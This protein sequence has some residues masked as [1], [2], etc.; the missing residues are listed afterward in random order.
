MPF[1][2]LLTVGIIGAGTSLA[3]GIL[4]SNAATKAA[5]TQS[6]ASL[7]AARLANETARMQADA[8]L[9]AS[10]EANTLGE[11]AYEQG[12]KDL[13]PW[14]EVGGE[15]IY[16]LR[17]LMQPEGYLAKASPTFDETMQFNKSDVMMD[18]GF[19]F[20]MEEAQKAVER[21]AA[22]RGGL[23][24]GR[25]AKELQRVSQG[26]ASDEYGKA[27]GR[28]YGEAADKYNQSLERFRNN[29]QVDQTDKS[30]LF[31]RLSSLSGIGQTTSSESANLGNT[32]AT[33]AGR[34]ATEGANAAAGIIT[35]GQQSANNFSTDAAAARASGYVGGANAWNQALGT[36]AG[37]AN[38]LWTIKT[39]AKK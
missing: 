15:A 8:V 18:P 37:T 6:Q 30:N 9:T 25:T 13:E 14:R 39:L 5:E 32:Y 1:G 33:N 2:G 16:T 22:G 12:R 31:N 23:L 34:S 36:G 7:E 3:S 20:R 26:I 21:S 28:T 27:Y 10:R 38:D 17:D 11:L 4:G 24:G 35:G 29:F 19:D